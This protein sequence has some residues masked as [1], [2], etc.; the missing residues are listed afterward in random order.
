MN[1]SWYLH[2]NQRMAVIIALLGPWPGDSTEIICSELKSVPGRAVIRP[3]CNQRRHAAHQINPSQ[4]L[5]R[6]QVLPP[7]GS[8]CKFGFAPALSVS[9]GAPAGRP[10]K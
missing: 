8:F 9:V 5:H 7:G 1:Q 10:A 6:Q 3:G 4:R 2:G